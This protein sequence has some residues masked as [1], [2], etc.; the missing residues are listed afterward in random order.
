[1]SWDPAWE[2]VFSTRDW[3]RYPPEELIR[4]VARHF[5]KATDRTRIKI[6]E[7]GCG[8]GANIWFL[9]REGFQ[10]FGID[11]SPTAVAKANKYLKGENL[12]ARLL[13][14]DA[15]RLGALYLPGS[16]DAVIDVC[17]LQHN[18][19]EEVRA[20]LNQARIAL[21]PG[22][23]MFSMMCAAGTWGDGLG[24]A[25]EP[26]SYVDVSEGPY[27]GKG[28]VHFFTLEEVENLFS[29]FVGLHIESSVRS[30]D[31]RRREIRHWV[32]EGALP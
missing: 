17:C 13:V 7:I 30:L 4:F 29:D 18:R 20:I 12:P 11:G 23:R 5:F 24:R 3:G 28:L 2:D 8:A 16:F 19:A 26:G 15:A 32:V 31:G 10:T 9:A 1:M 14:G 22:G 6:L 27:A 21:K 25:V